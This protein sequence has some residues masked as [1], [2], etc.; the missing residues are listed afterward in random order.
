MTP[1][2]ESLHRVPSF[3][4]HPIVSFDLKRELTLSPVSLIH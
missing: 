4:S 3:P 2:E 1:E